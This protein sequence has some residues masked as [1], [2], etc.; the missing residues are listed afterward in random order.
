MKTPL[1]KND[2][3]EPLV[4]IWQQ[5]P[6]T[7]AEQT[8]LSTKEIIDKYMDAFHIAPYFHIIFN[9]RT[10]EM[11]YVSP[12]ITRILGYRPEDFNLS[13]AI[14][15]IHPDDLSY[16]YHY[17][18]SATRFFSELP[19]E[20]FFKYKFSYDYRIRT[21]TGHYKRVLQQVIPVYYFPEGGARTLGIFTDLDH[22]NVKG[23]PKLSFIGMQGAPSYYNVHLDEKF[24]R[25]PQLFTKREAEILHCII[26]GMDNREIAVEL[27]LSVPTIRTHHKSILQKAAC[28]TVNELL[29]KAIREGW[30]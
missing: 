14:N 22:L 25:S 6:T 2:K 3:T 4:K 20:L 7:T 15:N 12:E 10:T 1:Q 9:T 26:Q 21:Q 5:I 23:K 24:T 27:N 11:E 17:E 8:D 19:E 30:I 29:I 13:L 16:Y 18:Q 28:S